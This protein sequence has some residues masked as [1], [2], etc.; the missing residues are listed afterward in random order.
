MTDYNQLLQV[1]NAIAEKLMQGRKIGLKL[2]TSSTHAAYLN[3][4]I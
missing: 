3:V 4:V 1:A 2:I